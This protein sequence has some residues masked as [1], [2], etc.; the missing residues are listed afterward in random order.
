MALRPIGTVMLP[1]HAALGGFDHAC[2]CRDADHLCV[3]H[4][5]NDAVEVIDLERRSH[6]A[7]LPGFPG[8]AGVAVCEERHLLLATCRREGHVALTPLRV[9]LRIRRI[10][11]GDRPNGLAVAS[12]GDVALA[13]CVGGE[14]AGPSMAILDLD[15]G[16][17]LASAPLPGRA[18]WVVHDRAEG[19][20]HINVAAPPQI[21]AVRDRPPFDVLR[22][23]SIPVAGPHG[24][25][26]DEARGLLHC[27]C[28]GGVVITLE[29]GSGRIVGQVPIAGGPDV[30]FFNSR[31]AHLYVA[32]GDPGVVQVVDP[33]NAVVLETIVTG[34]DAH[35]IGF[36]PEREH[37]YAFVPGTHSAFVFADA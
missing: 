19:C 14:I 9:A 3:A 4:T 34:K 37:V 21:V 35:T 8:V 27:A 31:R 25:E 1:P 22:S 10:D 33:A 26:L 29:A 6:D 20:F 24:L 2:V 12:P 13:A 28:D 36:D 16:L 7:T 18:R 17:V 5:A 30:V 23:V 15:R 11:V 32:I